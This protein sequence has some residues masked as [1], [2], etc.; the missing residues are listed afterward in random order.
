MTNIPTDHEI[1]VFVQ[2]CREKGMRELDVFQA[3]RAR[4][5]QP[6]QAAEPVAW[7]DPWTGTKVT[8]DY[9][10]YGK[11][12]IPLYTAPQPVGRVPLTKREVELLDGMIAVQLD[13]ADRCDSVPNRTRADRQKGWDMERVALLKKI[14]QGGQHGTE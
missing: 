9:D 1:D 10:A 13:H 14:K 8:T 5:G 6:A 11:H 3:V 2:V 7:L 12:G 4:W